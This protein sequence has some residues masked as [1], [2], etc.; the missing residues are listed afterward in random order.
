MVRICDVEV[1]FASEELPCECHDTDPTL[2]LPPVC[3]GCNHAAGTHRIV[4]VCRPGTEICGCTEP[5]A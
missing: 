2:T 5:I 3:P 4:K 1:R